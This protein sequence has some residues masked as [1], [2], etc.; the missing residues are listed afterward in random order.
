[1]STFE[2]AP[3]LQ[4]TVP[5]ATTGYHPGGSAWGLIVLLVLAGVAYWFVRRRRVRQERDQQERDRQQRDRD[6]HR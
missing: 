2:E 5:L 4:L 3:V 6:D 1:M